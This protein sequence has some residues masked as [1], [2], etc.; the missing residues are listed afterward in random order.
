SELKAEPPAELIARTAE[1]VPDVPMQLQSLPT[2][3]API[4][5]QSAPTSDRGADEQLKMRPQREQGEQVDK[6]LI[7]PVP[8]AADPA[9]GAASNIRFEHIPALVAAALALAAVIIRKVFKL[10]LVRR[11]RR[12]RSALRSQWEAVSA[13]RAPVSPASANMVSA[14][15]YA[16]VVDDP[17]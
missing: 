14:V 10:F 3:A 15:R 16:D 17:V 13:T 2:S 11:L 8:T 9:A 6:P 5:P 12:R 7:T 1:P 4:E